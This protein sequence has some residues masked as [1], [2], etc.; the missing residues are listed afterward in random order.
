M[1]TLVRP[2][3]DAEADQLDPPPLRIAMPTARAVPDIGGIES[4]VAEVSSRL[5]SAGHRVT[6]LA[7]DRERTLPTHEVVDEVRLRRFPAFPASR[8]WYFSPGLAWGVLRGRWDLVH[9][10][11]IHTLVP[12]LA[13]LAALLRRVPYVV[14]F[15]TGGSSSALRTRARRWQFALLAPLLRRAARLIAVSEFEARRFEAVLGW[16]EGRIQVIRNGGSLPTPDQDVEPDPDLIV[17][18]GRLERYKGHHRV[19]AAL[20]TLLRTRPGAH[21]EILGSGPFEGELLT[22]AERLGVA[23]RVRVRFI[24]PPDRLEMAR[25]LARAGVVALLSDYEAH[26][27]AVMEALTVDRPV[28]VA[29]TSGLSELV[30]AGWAR[31]VA[32]DAAAETVA[33]VLSAQLDDAVLPPAGALP[34]WESCVAQ[35]AEVHRAA[36]RR[37]C[38]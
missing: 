33:A 35:L 13:M 19:V 30:T 22:L 7:T 38:R 25:S 26:P 36:A 29:T 4:H 5:V 16:P 31:G 18:L 27:V 10:Q 20:P 14:T 9:V 6:V 11:G 1:S 34:T 8:D 15:H 21:I 37:S 2:T 32:P 23:D 24:P 3:G 12:P 17:S 28:V